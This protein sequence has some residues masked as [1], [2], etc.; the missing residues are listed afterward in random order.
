M[1]TFRS[2]YSEDGL[3][4]S[5][6]GGSSSS[7]LSF[8]S[9]TGSVDSRS[10]RP[11][12]LSTYEQKFQARKAEKKKKK[13]REAK[14][15]QVSSAE[16]KREADREADREA[17][18]LEMETWITKPSVLKRIER[19]NKKRSRERMKDVL[20]WYP[21]SEAADEVHP[22]FACEKGDSNQRAVTEQQQAA[23]EEE[24]ESFAL[25]LHRQMGDLQ[26]KVAFVE[27]QVS[28]SENSPSVLR[29]KRGN[30]LRKRRVGREQLA[31]L[32]DESPHSSMAR[33]ASHNSVG[34][35]RAQHPRNH[36][37][38]RPNCGTATSD[39]RAIGFLAGSMSLN[40]LHAVD[41]DAEDVAEMEQFLT[42]H[43][44]PVS[45]SVPFGIM[46]APRK[47]C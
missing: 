23:D 34:L 31:P 19:S 16:Q 2:E 46:V 14:E 29:Q 21:P 4:T 26:Q 24:R 43:R 28:S 33:S 8:S 18:K 30:L 7:A 22:L 35:R 42:R 47:G 17:R 3:N 25:A 27:R 1:E 36:P 11:D 9:H 38:A 10:S 40:Q 15:N 39:N 32:Q 13:E 20:N 45:I 6:L 44:R 37:S 12:F 41:E 5:R